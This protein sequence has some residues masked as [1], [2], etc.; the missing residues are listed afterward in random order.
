M[1]TCIIIKVL[2][3]RVKPCVDS[4]FHWYSIAT[5]RLQPLKVN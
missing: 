3:V 2:I 1:N 5:F 4:C